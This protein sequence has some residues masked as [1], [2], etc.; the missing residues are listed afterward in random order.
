MHV[1]SLF[2]QRFTTNR[3]DVETR[4]KNVKGPV[5]L[6]PKS[7]WT[8]L[9]FIRQSS[10]SR[11]R[12]YEQNKQSWR[13]NEQNWSERFN[14]PPNDPKADVFFWNGVSDSLWYHLSV[15]HGETTN[16]EPIILIM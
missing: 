10:R 12:G 7:A 1:Q 14:H 11:Q 5:W 8:G 2:R 6:G 4:V 16:I 9:W 3:R 15:S 13:N